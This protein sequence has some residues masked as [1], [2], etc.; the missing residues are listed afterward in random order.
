MWLPTGLTGR[1]AEFV[2]IGR[3]VVVAWKSEGWCVWSPIACTGSW[4]ELITNTQEYKSRREL[5]QSS[6]PKVTHGWC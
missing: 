6:C 3:N 2:N 4:D 1:A 5:T